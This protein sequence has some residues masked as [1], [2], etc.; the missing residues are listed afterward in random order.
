M[1]RGNPFTFFYTE[2]L[3]ALRQN[4]YHS[5]SGL[6]ARVAQKLY[7]VKRWSS[8]ELETDWLSRTARHERVGESAFIHEHRRLWA[9]PEICHL[10][11]VTEIS[12][13]H[14]S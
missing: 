2:I 9:V 1:V 10:R 13:S 3:M 12:S 4:H 8:T 7:Y 5:C 11:S 6:A 14:S